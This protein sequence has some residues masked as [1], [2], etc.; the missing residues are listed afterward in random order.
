MNTP[1]SHWNLSTGRGFRAGWVLGMVHVS[2]A[3]WQSFSCLF[4]VPVSH[5]PMGGEGQGRTLLTLQNTLTLNFSCFKCCFCNFFYAAKLYKNQLLILELLLFVLDWQK[6]LSPTRN[7]LRLHQTD[8]WSSS[9]SPGEHK[10]L[11]CAQGSAVWGD[12][13]TQQVQDTC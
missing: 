2:S 12:S 11:S 9:S 6:I 13:N 10:G 3:A 5:W 8:L 4:L 1:K 7:V